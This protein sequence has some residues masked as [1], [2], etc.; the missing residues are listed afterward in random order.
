MTS[1]TSYFLCSPPS[2][3]FVLGPSCVSSLA[4]L[5]LDSTLY[6]GPTPN[7]IFHLSSVK[8]SPF[9]TELSSEDPNVKPLVTVSKLTGTN[10]QEGKIK[11]KKT[12]CHVDS[13]ATVPYMWHLKKKKMIQMHL[14][15]K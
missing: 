12:H 9:K 15:T 7:A 14:F 3:F 11:K 13:D 5:S 2:K 1:E 8:T 10:K 6:S 4:L